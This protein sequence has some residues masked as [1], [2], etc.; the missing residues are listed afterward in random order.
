MSA[1]LAFGAFDWLT[2]GTH[3]DALVF[4]DQTRDIRLKTGKAQSGIIKLAKGCA[5]IER[6]SQW[7]VGSYIKFDHFVRGFSLLVGYSFVSKNRDEVTPKDTEKFSVS[8]ANTDQTLLGYK[9][10]T[11]NFWAEYD[12]AQEDK[13]FGPRI[14][15]Y[16]N[17]LVGGKRIFTTGM[18]GGNFGIELAWDIN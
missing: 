1:D 17:L 2:L 8:I 5:S 3:F 6:G 9:I 15:A 12:F 11:L 4:A 16:Y 18:G 14:A 7:E 10:H 13:V